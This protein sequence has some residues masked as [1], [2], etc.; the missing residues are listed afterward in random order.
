MEKSGKIV[1]LILDPFTTAILY[2]LVKKVLLFQYDRYSKNAIDR[3]MSMAYLKELSQGSS[4]YTENFIRK[5]SKLTD[6]EELRNEKTDP[7]WGISLEE[8][9]PNE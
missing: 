3:V 1:K 9:R 6:E 8:M 7:F 4:L 5:V 2:E